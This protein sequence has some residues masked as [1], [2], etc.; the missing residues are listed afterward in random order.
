MSKITENFSSLVEGASQDEMTFIEAYVFAGKNP[1]EWITEAE[2]NPGLISE[3]P[4]YHGEPINH[5]IMT[6]ARTAIILAREEYK[7]L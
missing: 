7:N 1:N 6:M 4:I 5:S 3:D 2:N